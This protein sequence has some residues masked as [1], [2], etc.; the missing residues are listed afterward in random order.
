[1]TPISISFSGS[2]NP[3]YFNTAGS[4]QVPNGISSVAAKKRRVF[5]EEGAFSRR[6]NSLREE[7]LT[8]A[9]Q[10]ISQL[11]VDKPGEIELTINATDGIISVVQAI[12][13]QSGAWICTRWE[14]H[15]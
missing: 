5:E 1:M 15:P 14:E 13:F 7:I 10:C 3:K 4:G 6:A 8:H 9:R 2:Q 12:Y 11:I